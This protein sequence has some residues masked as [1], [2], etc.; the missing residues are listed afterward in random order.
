MGNEEAMFSMILLDGTEP[1]QEAMAEEW[2]PWR[3]GGMGK[4][5]WWTIKTA[6]NLDRYARKGEEGGATWR[7]M[8]MQTARAVLRFDVYLCIVHLG[9]YLCIS[10]S[11]GTPLHHILTL[12]GHS[13]VRQDSIPAGLRVYIPTMYV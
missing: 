13:P 10:I 9:A 7:T 6:I 11:L 5:S 4:T 2:S 3:S 1:V 8:C 12:D